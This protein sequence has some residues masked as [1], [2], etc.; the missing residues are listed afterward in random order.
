MYI[1][2]N[3]D[4]CKQL[5]VKTGTKIDILIERSVSEW[6]KW[7]KYL[8]KNDREILKD[9]IEYYM[10]KKYAYDSKT[11]KWSKKELQEIENFID[12]IK[13]FGYR[14]QELDKYITLRKK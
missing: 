14:D 8:D 13:Q 1:I 4:Q 6:L 2:L 3:E 5:N 7:I 9:T 10:D 11:I 12:A